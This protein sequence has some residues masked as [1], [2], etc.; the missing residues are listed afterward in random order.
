M[1]GGSRI[2]RERGSI[3]R[4]RIKRLSLEVLPIS[5]QFVGIHAAK[6]AEGSAHMKKYLSLYDASALVA[7]RD[8][9]HYILLL[10]TRIVPALEGTGSH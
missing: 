4:N 7:K 10:A 9:V 5:R 2:Y 1:A 8:V 6:S 3:V